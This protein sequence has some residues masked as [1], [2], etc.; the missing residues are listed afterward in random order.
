M[1]FWK[2]ETPSTNSC[3]RLCNSIYYAATTDLPLILVYCVNLDSLS[4][5]LIKKL[6]D[7]NINSYLNFIII[8]SS[9]YGPFSC[10]FHSVL[11]STRL[12]QITAPILC[13]LV[14]NPLLFWIGTDFACNFWRYLIHL[15]CLES[16][17]LQIFGLLL[18]VQGWCS[19]RYFQCIAAKYTWEYLLYCI[20]NH[21]MHL[22]FWYVSGSHFLWIYGTFNS[23]ASFL[24]HAFF[25]ETFHTNVGWKVIISWWCSIS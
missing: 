8:E 4:S 13:H 14:Q 19:P 18:M 15:D 2:L 24:W 25:S 6:S 12:C 22:K 11:I 9:S 7:C 17:E 21:V 10:L 1:Y 23:Y 20:L 16:T 5:T 3:G